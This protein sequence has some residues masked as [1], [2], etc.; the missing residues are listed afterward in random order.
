M[1]GKVIALGA[2][3]GDKVARGAPVVTIEAMK[4][5]VPIAAP[6]DGVVAVLSVK[7]GESVQT[8]QLVAEIKPG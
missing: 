5:N 2:K 4:M 3:V 7:V 8:G 1:P 6:A